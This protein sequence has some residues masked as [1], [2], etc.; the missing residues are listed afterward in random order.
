MSAECEAVEGVPSGLIACTLGGAELH[1]LRISP[2]SLWLRVDGE[3]PMD[4]P[5]ALSFYRPERGLYT[6]LEVEYTQSGPVRREDFGAS[7]RLSIS[8]PQYAAAVRR[9]LADLANYVTWRCEGGMERC[10]LELTDA[11]ACDGDDFCASLEEQ[12]AEWFGD[13]APIVSDPQGRALALI[14]SDPDQ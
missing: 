13:G 8:D 11:P 12:Y 5:L 2:R 7:V 6:R 10:T 3:L 4:A 14:L 9:S 1:I